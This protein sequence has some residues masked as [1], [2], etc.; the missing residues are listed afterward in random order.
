MAEKK[1]TIDSGEPK[2][3]VL[4][5]SGNGE[6]GVVITHP[7]PLYGGDMY[8]NVV[9]SITRS[10]IEMGY[11][12]LRFNFRGVGQSEGLYD[13]GI[14]EQDDIRNAVTY[15][16]E[17]GCKHI[18]LAGYSFGAWVSARGIKS[19]TQVERLV[20]VSPPVS[21]M[22]FSSLTY[23]P[24]IEF[25][26]V[27]SDDEFADVKETE[28]ALDTW[29]PKAQLKIIDGADHFYQGKCNDLKLLLK[30]FLKNHNK[31]EIH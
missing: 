1:I 4:L 13:D 11:S 20:M 19:Y 24:K 26:I 3:E 7:H 12:T 5:E 27:G 21:F 23:N 10:Y 18:D 22:D 25:V 29:N 28:Q 17:T 15:L 6:R 9:E 14:G 30:Q 8:N 31:T 2:I 16:C